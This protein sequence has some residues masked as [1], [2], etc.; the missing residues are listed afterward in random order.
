[1]LTCGIQPKVA[2]DVS[3]GWR[4]DMMRLIHK[5]ELESRRVIFLNATLGQEASYGCNGDIGGPGRMFVSHL[6]LDGLVRICESAVPSCLLH[7][8]LSVDEDECLAGIFLGLAYA[9]NELGEDDLD[10]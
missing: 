3:V 10:F 1:M 2:E 4:Y 8:F 9:V 7:K 5:D 6:Y